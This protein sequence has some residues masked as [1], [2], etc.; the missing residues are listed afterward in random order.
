MPG[1]LIPKPPMVPEDATEA[2][3]VLILLKAYRRALDRRRMHY[4]SKEYTGEQLLAMPKYK[5]LKRVL[6][7]VLKYKIVPDVWCEAAVHF[8]VTYALTYAGTK[9]NDIPSQINRPSGAPSVGW[10]YSQK[11]VDER[12]N[13]YDRFELEALAPRSIY[14][15]ETHILTDAYNDLKTTL[16]T[17]DHLDANVVKYVVKTRFPGNSYTTMVQQA[18]YAAEAL[19]DRVDQRAANGEYLWST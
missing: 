11:R 7:E 14:P 4:D 5:S 19:Q 12:F 16:L 9:W 6:P 18:I 8:W 13:F 3:G 10:V 17:A 2:E 1:A 15:K